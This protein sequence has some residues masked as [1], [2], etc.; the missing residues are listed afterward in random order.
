LLIAGIVFTLVTLLN[1]SRLI[2]KF[3]LRVG[4]KLIPLWANAMGFI[5]ALC[6]AIWM[7]YSYVQ[8]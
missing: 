8:I 5:V 6:L 7:F 4:G 3:E 2:F 1:L